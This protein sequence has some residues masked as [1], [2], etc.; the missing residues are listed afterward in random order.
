MH[1]FSAETRFR[2]PL[3]CA[4]VLLAVALTWSCG[5][6]ISSPTG[7]DTPAPA[8]DPATATS[9]TFSG[10]VQPI[11]NNDCVSCHGGSRQEKGYDFRTYAGVLRA[12]TPG[13]A[14]S[15]LVRVTQPGGQMYPEFRGSAAAKSETI[16]R[17]VIDFKAAQ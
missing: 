3:L 2:M 10:D 7:P 6:G 9:L 4:G 8:Q 5:G 14:S 13:S 16:R 17:W 15:I 1:V 11:I 12:V